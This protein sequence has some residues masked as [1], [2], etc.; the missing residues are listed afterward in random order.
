[1]PSCG[2]SRE[3]S[4]KQP[5]SL[6][7]FFPCLIFPRLFPGF[8]DSLFEKGTHAKHTCDWLFS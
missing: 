5:L 6:R 7:A 4:A 2:R 3:Q 1:L 8:S